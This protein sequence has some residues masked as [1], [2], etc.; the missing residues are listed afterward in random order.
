MQVQ[1]KKPFFERAISPIAFQPNELLD[2]PR[3]LAQ[4]LIQSGH[5]V[6][7]ESIQTPPTL[8]TR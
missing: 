2:L 7:V 4:Q 8:E 3:K 6:R 5:A 1:I